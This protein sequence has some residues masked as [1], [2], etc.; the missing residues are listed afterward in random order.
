[1][2]ATTHLDEIASAV[3]PA[4]APKFAFLASKIVSAFVAKNKMPVEELPALIK[5]VHAALVDA[6]GNRQTGRAGDPKPMVA[7][8]DSITP[9][10]IICLNDGK[11]LKLLK[12]HLRTVYNMTPDD[13]RTMWG[14]PFDYPMVAPNYA[15]TR[16]RLAKQIGLGRA[17]SARKPSN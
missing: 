14:L 8:K 2:S 3:E 7:I 5:T 4:A 12:R 9:E 1:M 10:Y 16:S 15:V 17:P 13:Y 11:R 6:S